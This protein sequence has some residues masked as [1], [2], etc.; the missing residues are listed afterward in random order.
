MAGYLK[1]VLTSNCNVTESKFYILVDN[2]E[3]GNNII[4]LLNSEKISEYLHLCKYSG[5][6]SRPVIESITFD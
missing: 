4:N 3:E 2:E 5:F 6:N 1:P